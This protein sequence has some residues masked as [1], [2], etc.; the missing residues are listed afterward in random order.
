MK[1]RAW[2]VACAFLLLAAGLTWAYLAAPR[3]GLQWENLFGKYYRYDSPPPFVYT[4]TSAGED[5]RR[6]DFYYSRDESI[7]VEY[8]GGEDT[9]FYMEVLDWNQAVGQVEEASYTVQVNAAHRATASLPPRAAAMAERI[10]L[11]DRAGLLWLRLAVLYILLAAAAALLLGRR[12]FRR[13]KPLEPRARRARAV[14]AGILLALALLYGLRAPLPAF[15][16][17]WIPEGIRPVAVQP[18]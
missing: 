18:V 4:G 11:H 16:E 12:L 7:R 6:T 8:G 5:G 15:L 17:H 3:F 13:H 9:Y 10:L 2:I 1:R 14:C